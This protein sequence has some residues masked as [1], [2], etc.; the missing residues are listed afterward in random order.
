MTEKKTFGNAEELRVL[1][2]AS[3]N[4]CKPPTEI[5]LELAKALGELSNEEAYYPTVREQIVTL[6]GLVL[7]DEFILADELAEVR[8]RLEK[9]QAAYESTDFS[10][11]EHIRI[12]HALEAH[13]AEVARLE[14]MLNAQ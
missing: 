2:N 11:E 1:L 14:K 7:K 8:T 13:R 4:L 5:L 6:Y 9:I 3:I 12:G 10:E